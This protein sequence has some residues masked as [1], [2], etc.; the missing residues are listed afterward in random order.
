MA[1]GI[2]DRPHQSVLN[3]QTKLEDIFIDYCEQSHISDDNVFTP[4]LS[5][6]RFKHG[7][8]A[9]FIKKFKDNWKDIEF[10]VNEVYFIT[11]KDED[12]PFHI[13]QTIK[14]GETE[15]KT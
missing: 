5:L 14:L 10:G 1:E 11:R 15:D 12:D 3:I 7:E 2:I 6:G 9:D 4:H 13:K 8:A